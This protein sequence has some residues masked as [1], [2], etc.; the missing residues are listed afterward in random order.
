MTE[1]I[2]IN[3]ISIEEISKEISRMMKSLYFKAIE[4]LRT[5]TKRFFKDDEAKFRLYT[6]LKLT[7][8]PLLSIM[9]TAGFFWILVNMNLIFFRANEYRGI[10]KFEEIFFDFLSNSLLDQAPFAALL[11]IFVN[12]TAIYISDILLRPFRLIGD[13][14]EKR[15][16]GEEASYNPDFFTDL[17]LLSQFTEFFFSYMETA[18]LNERLH[19]VAV[20]KKYTKIHK[21]VFESTF[22][23]HYLLYILASLLAVSIALYSFAVGLYEDIIILANQTLPNSPA[24]NLFLGDQKAIIDHIIWLVLGVTSIFYIGLASHLYNG[25]ASP[26]FAIFATM[27]SFLKGNYSQRVH[28]IGYPFLRPQTRKLNKYLDWIEK[29]LVEKED[30]SLS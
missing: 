12:I 13:Y 26:A 10:D 6:S 22:F 2:I 15:N 5:R 3:Y 27:R 29:N 30:K 9:A 11:L 21:P 23:L 20:P 4:P 28:L 8:I 7:C 14:C 18:Q 19:Q 1:N 24:I 17:R 16:Q 25:V